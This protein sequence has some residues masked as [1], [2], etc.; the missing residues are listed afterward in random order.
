MRRSMHRLRSHKCCAPACRRWRARSILH[1]KQICIIDGSAQL[2][3][4]RSSNRARVRVWTHRYRDH[5]TRARVHEIWRH[6]PRY[7]SRLTPH[8][9]RLIYGTGIMKSDASFLV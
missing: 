1:I 7:L 3:L 9:I 8:S 5:R 4:K 6:A 2:L